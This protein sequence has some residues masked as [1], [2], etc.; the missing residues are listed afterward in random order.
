M[1]CLDALHFAV[2]FTLITDRGT[3]L[4]DKKVVSNA[5]DYRGPKRSTSFCVV[6]MI[7]SRRISYPSLHQTEC[8]DGEINVQMVV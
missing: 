4:D 1:P 8:L 5:T 3:A 7:L 6:E 2:V